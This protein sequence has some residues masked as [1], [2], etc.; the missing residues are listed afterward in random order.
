MWKRRRSPCNLAAD[1]L[2]IPAPFE[3]ERF[4]KS[5]AEQRGRPLLLLPL[6]GPPNPDLPCGIWIG[7]DV[8]D[9]VFYE[10]TAS[11]VLRVQIV[12]HE[13]A[14]MLLGHVAPEL[15]VDQDASD[16]ELTAA[17]AHFEHLLERSSTA[18]GAMDTALPVAE[19][20][21]AE[22]ARVRAATA[23]TKAADGELG[24]NTDRVINL[25]GR[26]KFATGQERD[27]ETLATLILERASRTEARSTSA[28]AADRLARLHDALGHPNRS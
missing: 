19:I 23:A 1:Q 13:I 25:M 22:A 4:C 24:L 14:H 27:A 26:S 8:A 15:D 6:D 28:E 3:L 18:F 11:D 21:R 7:L 5:I 17:S 12:L 20:M 10:A 9:L 2:T 16:E